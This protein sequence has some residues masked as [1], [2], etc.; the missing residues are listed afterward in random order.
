MPPIRSTRPTTSRAG[1]YTA[2]E[3][4]GLQR[5]VPATAIGRNT[6]GLSNPNPIPIEA[7]TTNHFLGRRIRLGQTAELLEADETE[8]ILFKDTDLY[9]VETMGDVRNESGRINKIAA[10][11]YVRDHRISSAKINLHCLKPAIAAAEIGKTTRDVVKDKAMTWQKRA[12]QA[13]RKG[14]KGTVDELGMGAFAD[15]TIDDRRKLWEDIFNQDPY[16]TSQMVCGGAG[17]G[18]DLVGIFGSGEGPVRMKWRKFFENVF[19]AG[20]QDIL[21]YALAN[22]DEVTQGQKRAW[23]ARW[24]AMPHH[25]FFV[26][27][28]EMGGIGDVPVRPEGAH[29]HRREEVQLEVEDWDAA[30]FQR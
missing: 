5:P 20:C 14:V 6:R 2:G 23:Y 19:V 4:L 24:R 1:P 18:V 17:V 8:I 9:N 11:I 30:T 15:S 16:G 28:L 26:E 21:K 3:N 13:F 22:E 25:R 29:D 10:T 7:M 27:E 12:F